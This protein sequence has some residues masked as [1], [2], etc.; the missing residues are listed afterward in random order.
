M[1]KAKHVK[2]LPHWGRHLNSTYTGKIAQLAAILFITALNNV[3]LPTLLIAVNNNG[4][5][6][7]LYLS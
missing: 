2:T 4:L 7:M 5:N 6:G 3:V 1:Q